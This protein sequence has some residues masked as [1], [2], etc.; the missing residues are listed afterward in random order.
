MT[1]RKNLKNANSYDLDQLSEDD[2]SD[3]VSKSSSEDDDSIS[4]L[5][6]LEVK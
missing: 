6:N 2:F 4:D 5:D 1:D 3:S